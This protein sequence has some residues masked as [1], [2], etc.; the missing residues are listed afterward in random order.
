MIWFKPE[1]ENKQSSKGF[2][3]LKLSCLGARGAMES[4]WGPCSTPSLKG[5]PTTRLRARAFDFSINSSY[6]HSWTNVRDPAQQH[7]P[8]RLPY[9][10]QFLRQQFNALRAQLFWRTDWSNLIKEQSKMC[11]LHSFIYIRILT[12][13][14]RWFP[15]KLQCDRFEI[16]FCSQFKHNFTSIGW[17]CESK[18]KRQCSI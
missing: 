2:I 14:K 6:T 5:S 15:S 11:K 1:K 3:V 16:A 10:G 17:S 18:L 8:C 7:C 12:D 4:T 13:Y 9:H